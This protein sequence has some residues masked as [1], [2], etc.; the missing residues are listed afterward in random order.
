MKKTCIAFSVILILLYSLSVVTAIADTG[1]ETLEYYVSDA[2]GLLTI[3]QQQSLETAA[4]AVSQQYG[5]GI[6]IISIED[7]RDFSFSNI[8]E[9]AEGFFTHYQLG[10]GD[11]RNGSLLLLSMKE[12]DYALK[13]HGS[14]AHTAFTDYGSYRLSDRFLDNFARDDWYGGFADYIDTSGAFLARAAA[15][16]P[17]DVPQD[18]SRGLSSGLSAAIIIGVPSLIAFGACE[19]M[20]RQMKPVKKQ[21][22]ADDYVI[23]G[24]INLDVRSDVFVNRSVTRTV[25]ATERSSSSSGGGGTTINSGGFSG[26]SGKF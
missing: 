6:Y 9:C 2:A 1:T 23:P 3:E 5:C 13:A 14:I 16:D 19:G 24:G 11:E 26:H 7:Y 12:R 20:K 15:G 4:R 17:V 21:R 10:L 18:E 8:D 22:D 25:I